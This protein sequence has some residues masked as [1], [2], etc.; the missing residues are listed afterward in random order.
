MGP[1]YCSV[2]S[3]GTVVAELSPAPRTHLRE[4]HG[5]LALLAPHDLATDLP[6]LLA[7]KVKPGIKFHDLLALATLCG[8]IAA[9]DAETTPASMAMAGVTENGREAY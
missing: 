5:I 6:Q 3:A 2:S 7:P 4:H 9:V 1:L 8:T